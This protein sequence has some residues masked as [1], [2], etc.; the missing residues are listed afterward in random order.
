MLL[1]KYPFILGV[2]F[3]INITDGDVFGGRHGKSREILKDNTD[4][5]AQIHRIVIAQ[6]YPVEQD[7]ALGWLVEVGEEFDNRRF[8]GAIFA[9]ER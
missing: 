8:S 2:F 5:P 3:G 4:F 7:S 9:Y 1:E 6:I